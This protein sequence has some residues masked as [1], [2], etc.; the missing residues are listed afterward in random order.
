LLNAA[1]IVID[2]GLGEL[3]TARDVHNIDVRA[4]PEDAAGEGFIELRELRT[5]LD[6]RRR[7]VEA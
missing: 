4:L 6:W 2:T 1:Y 3:M 7:Q 5:Y